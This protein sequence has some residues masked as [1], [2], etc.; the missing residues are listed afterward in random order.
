MLNGMLTVDDIQY[1]RGQSA[2]RIVHATR[3]YDRID[4][5]QMN[6]QSDQKFAVR[7]KWGEIGG[8]VNEK[9]ADVSYKY[10]KTENVTIDPCAFTAHLSEA[11]FTDRKTGKVEKLLSWYFPDL[12]LTVGNPSPNVE[13]QSISTTLEPIEFV[14]PNWPPARSTANAHSTA[15]DH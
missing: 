13:F 7:M 8:K 4:P 5:K 9:A 15:D 11:V 10:L 6:F 3:D 2:S 14:E 12:R 1:V